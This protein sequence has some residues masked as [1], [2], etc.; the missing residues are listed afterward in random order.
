VKGVLDACAA[1]D[2]RKVVLMSSTAVY[3]ASPDNSTFLDEASPL[4]GSPADGYVRDLL[5]IEALGSSFR[6]QWPGMEL[7]V[8]RFANIVGT[9]ATTPMTQ[10]LRLQIPRV[11]FGFDPMMQ[12]IHEDDVVD[13]LV[14]A[15]LNN[16]PGVFNV[17]TED[18]MPLSRV[19][20]LAGRVPFPIPYRLA[21]R[22]SRMLAATALERQCSEPIPWDYLRYSLVADLSRMQAELAFMP[23]FTA[24]DGLRE[25]A[26]LRRQ[27][28]KN[29]RV[30]PANDEEL[31]R[32][33]IV[34][35]QRQ[36]D[37]QT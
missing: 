33:I 36:R 12:F 26:G 9:T 15:M 29:D 4:R 31:L 24:A 25:L 1:A 11:L 2:V 30:D 27:Q 23:N 34:R 22:G 13:G 28:E 32:E 14:H 19:L 3:G 21:Y 16:K 8:L 37:R 10:F 7:T 20:R 18:A 17:A 5:N 35:R 6:E